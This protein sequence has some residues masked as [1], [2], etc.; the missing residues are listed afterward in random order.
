VHVE[1]FVRVLELAIALVHCGFSWSRLDGGNG[2]VEAAGNITWIEGCGC[3][4]TEYSV[5]REENPKGTGN[6]AVPEI[7]GLAMYPQVTCIRR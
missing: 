7:Q 3:H 6:E 5:E 1:L 2:R 4:S